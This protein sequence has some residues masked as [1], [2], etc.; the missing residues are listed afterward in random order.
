MGGKINKK[1]IT[2][3]IIFGLY[4]TSY[5]IL[6]LNASTIEII[7]EKPEPESEIQIRAIIDTEGVEQAY[8]LIQECD[9]NTGICYE[10]QNL[11]LARL[12][13]STYRTSYLLK[14]PKATYIQY[15]LLVKTNFGW[16]TLI[17]EKKIDLEISQN[18]DNNGGNGNQDTPGFEII[19]IFLGILCMMMLFRK[20]KR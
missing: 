8:F 12:D 13:E 19:G 4:L 5:N 10:R 1:F 2:V 9:I 11:S 6:A 7:P 16:E 20:R 14:E 18:N 3:L 15:N 17:K